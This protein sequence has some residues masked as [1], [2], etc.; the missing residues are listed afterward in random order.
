M[1]LSRD[2]TICVTK[3]PNRVVAIVDRRGVTLASVRLVGSSGNTG[4]VVGPMLVY[5]AIFFD[6][7]RWDGHSYAQKPKFCRFH[8]LFKLS[9]D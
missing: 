5:P 7:N 8:G 9:L 4:D 2:C 6:R 3:K 1:T